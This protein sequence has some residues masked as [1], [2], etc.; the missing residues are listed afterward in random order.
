MSGRGGG[1][2]MRVADE[3]GKVSRWGDVAA[4]KASNASAPKI[5]HLVRRIGELFRPHRVALTITIVLVLISAAIG[6]LPPLL[7]QQAFDRGLFPPSGTP[8]VPVLLE[9]VGAMVL[10]WLVS[11]GLGVWQTYLTARVGNSVMGALR[12]RLFSHLQAMELG[13][14]TRT[15]TGTI[16]SRLQ[17][18]VGG[19]AGVLN[20]TIS[21]VVGNTVTVIAAFVA[22]L[23]LSWQMTL[24]AVILLPLLVIAQRRVG[25]VRARIATQTQES[26]SEM[27]AITQETLNVSGILLAKSFNRQQA[28][29]ERYAG[30]NDNQ[31][32]LQV[33]QQMSGQ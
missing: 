7:T 13:F 22:M 2:R 11:A 24:V 1:G 28:E 18:D 15:K 33:R 31:V 30:E 20:T 21:S 6:V 3:E 19:V 23:L 14:F 29:I 4:L 16:Q 32:T 12:V 25:Q 17:N 26:L 27:T 9:L 10:I 8:D 5:P